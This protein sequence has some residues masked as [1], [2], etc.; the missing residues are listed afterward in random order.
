M[1]QP[2]ASPGLPLI[3]ASQTIELAAPP[4]RFRHFLV[5][6]K[7]LAILEAAMECQDP[8]GLAR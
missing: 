2:A 4:F 1:Q 6:T 8:Q 3:T 7:T 5:K